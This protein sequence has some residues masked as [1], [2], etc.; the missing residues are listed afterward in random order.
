M[1]KVDR[2]LMIKLM[3]Q[4][5]E[6]GYKA[7]EELDIT[8]QKCVQAI[9]NVFELEK[10]INDLNAKTEYDKE[11]SEKEKKEIQAALDKNTSVELEIGE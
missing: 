5:I 8:D 4:K 6:E 11:M 10:T 9:V 1:F 7:I 2:E 3:K